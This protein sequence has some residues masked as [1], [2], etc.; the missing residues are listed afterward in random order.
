ML[1]VTDYNTFSDEGKKRL[2][3][4]QSIRRVALPVYFFGTFLRNDELVRKG[5]VVEAQ[6]RCAS[7]LRPTLS[8]LRCIAS[9]SCAA[10]TAFHLARS[11]SAAPG[12][13]RLHQNGEEQPP[14]FGTR[15][16]GTALST[17][18]GLLDFVQLRT[19]N[20]IVKPILSQTTTV[21]TRLALMRRA[22][23]APP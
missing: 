1:I 13:L 17:R 21:R 4:K 12:P 23:A 16:F 5:G 10:T 20:Q 18:R 3:R 8:G 19:K 22:I 7:T 15:D 2:T 11:P 9:S 6:R 14:G